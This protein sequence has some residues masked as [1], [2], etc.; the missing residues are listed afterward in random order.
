MTP[1]A[2]AVPAAPPPLPAQ[3]DSRALPPLIPL[4]TPRPLAAG[5]RRALAGQQIIGK[6]SMPGISIH[7]GGDVYNGPSFTFTPQSPKP[8]ATIPGFTKGKGKGSISTPPITITKTAYKVTSTPGSFKAGTF[9]VTTTP[10]PPA[11]PLTIKLP[12]GTLPLPGFSK[13]GKVLG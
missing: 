4:P 1:C 13:G 12:N 7:A 11:Q 5:P 10:A 3:L 8:V 9:N 6:G 2:S